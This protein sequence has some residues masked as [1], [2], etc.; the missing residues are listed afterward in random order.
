LSFKWERGSREKGS[1]FKG[2][3]VQGSRF[4]KSRGRGRKEIS[5]KAGGLEL[6]NE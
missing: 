3:K 5:M 4:R 1:K 6:C 2:E